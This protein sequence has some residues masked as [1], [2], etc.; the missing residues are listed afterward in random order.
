[1]SSTQRPSYY[2]R[3]ICDYMKKQP[4]FY[5]SNLDEVREALGFS[6]QSFKMGLDWC[7]AR[8]IIAL[9]SKPAHTPAAFSDTAEMEA[10]KGESSRLSSMLRAPALA[11]AS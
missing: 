6:E 11:E 9:D 10:L 8:Q 7:I 1:M 4:N 3:L 5:A 2:A